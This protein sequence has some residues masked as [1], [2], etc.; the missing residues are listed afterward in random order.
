MPTGLF[1]QTS[2]VA[3]AVV[4]FA[5][6]LNGQP[7]FITK[8]ILRATD[9]ETTSKI[10]LYHDK[11]EPAAYRV[12]WYAEGGDISKPLAE[13]TSDYL[14]LVPPSKEEIASNPDNENEK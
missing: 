10:A 6:I 13:L 9:S 2:G 11:D 5:V 4:D 3:T 7:R 14:F 1:F 8:A 12:T